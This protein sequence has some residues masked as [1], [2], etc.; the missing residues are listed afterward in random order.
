[1]SRSVI[2]LKTSTFSTYV[3]A[4]WWTVCPAIVDNVELSTGNFMCTTRGVF[5]DFYSVINYPLIKDNCWTNPFGILSTAAASLFK[6]S[7]TIL[8]YRNYHIKQFVISL[9]VSSFPFSASFSCIIIYYRLLCFTFLHN[10]IG[11]FL[12]GSLTN[13]AFSWHRQWYLLWIFKD[14]EFC[15]SIASVFDLLRTMD[16]WVCLILWIFIDSLSF[17]SAVAGVI[18][19]KIV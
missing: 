12:V 14:H 17:R 1:M 15:G 5:V 10:Q 7:S 9:L 19:A 8:L 13:F 16:V 3:V 18:F 2:Q 6:H 4:C 11:I